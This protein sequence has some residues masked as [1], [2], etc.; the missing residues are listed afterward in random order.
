M[1]PNLLQ[2]EGIVPYEYGIF[3]LSSYQ[4]RYHHDDNTRNDDLNGIGD[5]DDE[6]GAYISTNYHSSSSSSIIKS[7]DND[8]DSHG[9]NYVG[10]GTITDGGS[11][12][13][14]NKQNNSD[15]PML[16]LSST[17]MDH[18]HVHDDSSD[19]DSDAIHRTTQQQYNAIECR[20][21]TI[22]KII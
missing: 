19:I 6:T 14:P 11:H 21:H 15:D 10:D 1:V 12:D 5:Y 7:D 4:S 16:I 22:P 2:R 3:R 20:N 17:L 18:G 9:H 8:D 13:E